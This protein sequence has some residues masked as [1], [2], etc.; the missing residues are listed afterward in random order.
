MITRKIAK[1]KGITKAISKSKST[2]KGKKK[3]E[4]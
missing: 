4:N 1:I 2:N 3:V